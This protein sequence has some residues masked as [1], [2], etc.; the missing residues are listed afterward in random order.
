MIKYRFVFVIISLK[1]FLV[2]IHIGNA[3]KVAGHKHLLT[4]LFP[5]LAKALYH[6]DSRSRTVYNPIRSNYHCQCC[7]LHAWSIKVDT[8]WDLWSLK[9]VYKILKSYQN[10]Q[11]MFFY[12]KDRWQAWEQ[13]MF[14][15]LQVVNG[16]Y[17]EQDQSGDFRE[18]LDF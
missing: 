3:I 11:R 7:L 5:F 13:A 10:F 4:M 18:L 1:A 2:I 14:L 12:V 6:Q 9:I 16:F 17:I 8:S 15:G